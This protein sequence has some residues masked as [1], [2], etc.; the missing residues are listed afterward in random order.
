MLERAEIPQQSNKK[1]KIF[2][3][4]PAG[5]GKTLAALQFPKSIIVDG[6]RGT[7]QY[8][9]LLQEKKIKRIQTTNFY[10]LVEIVNDLKTKK[11]SYATLVI[12]PITTFWED[13]QE[14][15]HDKFV[16]VQEQKKKNDLLEDFGV[17]F[18]NKVKPEYKR[19]LKDLLD[20]D[21]NVIMTAHEK[22]KY[23][24]NQS[25][26]GITFDSNKSD[27]SFFDFVFRLFTSGSDFV[28]QTYKQRILPGE[29]RFPSYPEMFPW[30]YESLLK[31]CN[32]KLLEGDFVQNNNNTVNNLNEND[33]KSINNKAENNE[34]KNNNTSTDVENSNT[35]NVT[36]NKEETVNNNQELS[37]Q[38]QLKNK[39]KE[40]KITQKDFKDF[41]NQVVKWEVSSIKALS[42]NNIKIL[43]GNWDSKIIIKFNEFIQLQSKN[44]EQNEEQN[45]EQNNKQNNE[46]N[47]ETQQNKQQVDDNK[48][49]SN[50]ND[51]QD[52]KDINPSTDGK[53]TDEQIAIIRKRLILHGVSEKKFLNGFAME[54]FNTLTFDGANN[55]IKYFDDI[56]ED[57]KESK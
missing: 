19:L 13:I 4:G 56:I 30:N 41:L 25:I 2:M 22:D 50:N 49:Q 31:F 12:D 37:L 8:A 39:L 44:N 9:K 33:D 42:D 48:N 21:M 45:N 23:G 40:N 47:E 35:Q 36:D 10:D 5:Q 11:H 53:I 43:L 34:L 28:A 15:W 18:W 57:L 27:D 3:F 26:I 46:Q 32:R 55:I 24:S 38:D 6:E 7:D 20:L 16:Y 29:K 52:D 51:K 14:K 1:M 17:R 54:N